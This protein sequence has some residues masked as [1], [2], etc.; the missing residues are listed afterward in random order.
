MV[1]GNRKDL[2]HLPGVGRKTA[3]VVLNNAF[4]KP[5]VA[6]DTHVFRVSNRIGL[7]QG[8]TLLDV[9]DKLLKTIPKLNKNAF[10][11]LQAVAPAAK[12]LRT[13]V[14]LLM[15]PSSIISNLSPTASEIAFT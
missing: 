9:E 13:C 11:K 1:P 3:S 15:P 2:E 12:A 7:A 6:I 4:G 8:K 5:T 14:P 10:P